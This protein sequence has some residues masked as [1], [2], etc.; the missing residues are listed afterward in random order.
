MAQFQLVMTD[1]VKQKEVM[2]TFQNFN[3]NKVALHVKEGPTAKEVFHKSLLPMA[4]YTIEKGKAFA[5]QEWLVRIDPEEY[6]DDEYQGETLIMKFIS[7]R[8]MHVKIP[9]SQAT[10][11]PSL[12]MNTEKDQKSIVKFTNHLREYVDIYDVDRNVNHQMRPNETI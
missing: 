9:S 4:M 1:K 11:I 6:L 7:K 10:T 2:L 3:K 5:Y 8:N 12:F